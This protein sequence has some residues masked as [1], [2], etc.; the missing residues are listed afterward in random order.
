MLF[1]P[2]ED[3]SPKQVLVPVP[4]P[5]YVPVP[6]HMYSTPVPYPLP[7][8]VPIPVPCF[9]P[10]TRKSADGILKQIKV[11]TNTRLN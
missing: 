5:I 7:V 2:E 3:W 11:R 4:V 9:I 10:T 8:P 6:V 1:S